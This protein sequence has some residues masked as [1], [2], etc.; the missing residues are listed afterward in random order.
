MKKNIILITIILFTLFFINCKNKMTHKN[1]TLDKINPINDYSF[2]DNDCKSIYSGSFNRF[3]YNISNYYEI[4]DYKNI[5][6]IDT[7]AILSPKMLTPTASFC[8]I[9]SEQIINNRLLIINYKK[10]KRIFEN[11]ITNNIGLGTSGCEF[12]D[13]IDNGFLLSNSIGQSCKID[14]SIKIEFVIDK[15]FVTQ[16]DIKSNCKDSSFENQIKYKKNEFALEKFN[17][18]IIDSLIINNKNSDMN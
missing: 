12:I 11:V 17:R 13:I 14:Y 16:I 2:D 8:R 4:I 7:I 10:Q 9:E 18:R 3:G 1:I 15:P 5:N 6:L